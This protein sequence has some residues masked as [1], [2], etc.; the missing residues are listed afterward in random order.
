MG[1]L[2]GL[3]AR[4]HRSDIGHFN[5]GCYLALT[6]D[7]ERAIHEVTIACGL[8]EEC[9]DFARDEPDLDS[10]RTDPRFR[11]LL[12]QVAPDAGPPADDEHDEEF[13]DEGDA[14]PAGDRRLN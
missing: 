2:E 7:A 4:N 13:D 6:G 11:E 10:L 14:P 9:R 5:L 12:R 8:N 3:L 1:R